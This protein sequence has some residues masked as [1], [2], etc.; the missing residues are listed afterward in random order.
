MRKNRIY[1]MLTLTVFVSLLIP[2]L[3]QEGMFLD[4]ITYAA[5]SK[6]MAN[7]YGS[8]FN[9]HYTKILYSN[10]HEHPPLVFILQSGF[11]KLFGNAFYTER[12][13]SLLIAILTVIGIT[14]CWRLFNDKNEFKEYDWL[15]VLLWLS[16]PLVSWSYKNNLLENTMGVFTIFAVFFIL[17]SFIEKRIIYLF[18]GGV[19]IVLA[20]LS[21][22]PVGL[23]PIL[24]PLLYAIVYKSNKNALKYSAYLILFTISISYIFSIAFPELKQNIVLYFEQQLIPALSNKREITTNNRFTIILNLILELSLPIALLVYFT[25]REWIKTRKPDFLKDKKALIFLLIAITA[26]IPLIISLKQR[27]FYLIPSIPFYVLTISILVVPFVKRFIDAPSNSTLRW[28]KGASLLSLA[29]VLL[30]SAFQFGKFSRDKEKLTDVYAISTIIPEGTVIST[31]RD[32][33]SDWSL[34]AY[35]CRIGYLS[36]DCDNEHDYYLLERNSNM[37]KHVLE[38]YEIVNMNL[39]RYEMLRKKVEDEETVQIGE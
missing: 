14:Q 18:V 27:K 1:W 32:L 29:M 36:L 4:G 24:V 30:F 35:M 34:V 19:L 7:G 28:I 8:F 21:K 10:F 5:I 31:T 6:N 37:D 12:I 33:W 22:G 16:I 23:F 17:K 39:T 3:V 15:P 20:F 2:T 25:I 11:F 38:N 13:F 9:P 26:S